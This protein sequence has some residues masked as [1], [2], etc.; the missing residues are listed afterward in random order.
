LNFVSNDR[1][2]IKGKSSIQRPWFTPVEQYGHFGTHTLPQ[3]AGAWYKRSDG[4]FC[5]GEFTT[6][7]V[8]Y[9][10]FD[11]SIYE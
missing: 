8:I 10:C 6:V 9:N 3:K 2:E 11:K 1:Y 4:D 5:Y 7:S